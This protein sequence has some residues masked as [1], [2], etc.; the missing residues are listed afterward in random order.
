MKGRLWWSS[1]LPATAALC[2]FAN[3]AQAQTGPRLVGTGP[4][5]AFNV[6]ARDGNANRPGLID[7]TCGLVGGPAVASPRRASGPAAILVRGPTGPVRGL[8]HR[9]SRSCPGPFDAQPVPP[10]PVSLGEPIEPWVR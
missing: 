6:S 1:V 2:L 3:M 9:P 4:D 5:G 8:L 7:P 10:P